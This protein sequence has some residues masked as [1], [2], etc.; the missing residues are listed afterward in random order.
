MIMK[1]KISNTSYIKILLLSLA[2][3]IMSSCGGKKQETKQEK[4]IV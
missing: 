4:K 3:T 2:V 1:Q